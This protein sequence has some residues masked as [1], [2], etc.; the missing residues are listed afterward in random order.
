MSKFKLGLVGA[1]RMGKTHLRA[2]AAS[3][4]VEV[5]AITEASSAVRATLSGFNGHVFAELSGMLAEADLDGIL[6]AAP[7]GSH[8]DIVTQVASTGLPIL[9]EKPCGLVTA[10]AVVAA[11]IAKANAV[12]LQIAYWRRFVPEL[13]R[14]KARIDS[15]ALGE[16]YCILCYQWDQD[17]PMAA[18]RAKSGGIFVDMGVHEFDQLRWL[19]G[20]AVTRLQMT[21]ATAASVP[22]VPGDAESAAVLCT[23][24]GGGTGVI[25]LGRKHAPGDMCRVEVFGTGGV[26]ACPF[27]SPETGEETFLHALMRQAEGFASWARGG[28][29]GGASATDAIA[30]L[31][32]AERASLDL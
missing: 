19:S 3:D 23:L 20:Q 9:C 1:G 21:V 28:S 22:P 15:G 13:Q 7:S 26:E 27:L 14:L 25:S 32:L 2:L 31:E 24:S 12:L 8:L 29:A 17:L 16:I 4:M 30:A 18:F 11:Q 5:T 10:D 6:V